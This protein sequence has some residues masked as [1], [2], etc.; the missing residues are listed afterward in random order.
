MHGAGQ[1]S[2]IIVEMDDREEKVYK[3]KLANDINCNV[4]TRYEVQPGVN[5]EQCEDDVNYSFRFFYQDSNSCLWNFLSLHSQL[6]RREA[7]KEFPYHGNPT[8]L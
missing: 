5:T 6:I 8:N 2:L 4:E 1:S 3:T 7:S